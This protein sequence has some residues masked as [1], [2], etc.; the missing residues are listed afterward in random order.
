MD[1]QGE[2]LTI[3]VSQRRAQ[4][5]DGGKPEKNSVQE[6]EGRRH[7]QEFRLVSRVGCCGAVS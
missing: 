1:P 7:F 4:S 3:A 5:G 2:E 6:G